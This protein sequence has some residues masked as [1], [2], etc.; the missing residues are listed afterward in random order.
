MLGVAAGTA[1]AA[2]RLQSV[3]GMQAAA[4]GEAHCDL[5]MAGEAP[6]L[7]AAADG[8]ASGAMGCAFHPAVRRRERPG[9]NLPLRWQGEAQSYPQKEQW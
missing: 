4:S 8:V 5:R 1:L 3:G 7:R 9:R 2:A 6:Q